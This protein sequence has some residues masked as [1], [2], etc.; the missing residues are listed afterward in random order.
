MVDIASKLPEYNELTYL[1]DQKSEVSTFFIHLVMYLKTESVKLE[2]TS[3]RNIADIAYKVTAASDD[4][5]F[6]ALFNYFGTKE[7][8]NSG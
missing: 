7:N 1:S 6:S 4:Q 2:P 5:N 8:V 3:L